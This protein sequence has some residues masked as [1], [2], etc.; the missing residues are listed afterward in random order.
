[1]QMYFLTFSSLYCETV[2]Y[3]KSARQA[4]KNLYK[5]PECN[6]LVLF[7]ITHQT[8]ILLVLHTAQS[9][10]FLTSP[11]WGML[12]EGL[13][14]VPLLNGQAQQASCSSSKMLFSSLFKEEFLSITFS[15]HLGFLD[16]RW[17]ITGRYMCSLKT[18]GG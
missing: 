15:E 3:K 4:V 18:L 10:S 8:K 2:L 5:E 7:S 9:G 11:A 14:C 17:N 12:L 16:P 1:M 6:N 13:P